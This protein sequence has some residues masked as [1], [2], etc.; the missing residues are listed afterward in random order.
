MDSKGLRGIETTDFDGDGQ[1]DLYEYALF[2]DAANSQILAENPKLRFGTDGVV[3]FAHR[4]LTHTNSGILYT[5]EW[6]DNLVTGTWIRSWS[7][8]T[9]LP[10]GDPAFEYIEYQLQNLEEEELFFKFYVTTP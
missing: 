4:K 5:A 10:S 1:S 7:G 3:H 2:G 9:N 6:T 8:M